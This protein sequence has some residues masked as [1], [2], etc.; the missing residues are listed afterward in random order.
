MGSTE[1]NLNFRLSDFNEL[2][3]ETGLIDEDRR[4]VYLESFLDKFKIYHKKKLEQKFG[5]IDVPENSVDIKLFVYSDLKDYGAFVASLKN[6]I[7]NGNIQL[8]NRFERVVDANG[9]KE[10]FDIDGINS[11]LINSFSDN[12]QVASVMKLSGF[13]DRIAEGILKYSTDIMEG[14]E[15]D[16]MN[17]L[18][19]KFQSSIIDV[20]II[21]RYVLHNESNPF[22]YKLV[23][24]M[25]GVPDCDKERINTNDIKYAFGI[26]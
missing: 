22:N 13:D 3:V 21:A 17:L 24:E 26:K 23:M 19:E 14:R 6:H 1:K 10:A 7:N 20:I 5:M 8:S 2:F 12:E 9:T 15:L 25:Y 4:I 11:I 18:P 16:I